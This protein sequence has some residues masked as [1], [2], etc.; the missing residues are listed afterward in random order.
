MAV[1]SVRASAKDSPETRIQMRKFE[2]VIDEPQDFGGNDLAPS[3]VEVFLA[4]LA[5][6]INAIGQWVA[7][8]RGMC[9]RGM[10]IK[11]DGVIDSD[12]FFGK[13]TN[14]RA[15]FESISALIRVDTDAGNEELR[16]WIEQIYKRCPV[17]DNICNPTAFQIECK[18]EIRDEA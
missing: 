8:E 7:H 18:K 11:L 14:K 17:I 13:P 1:I 16:E 15:G 9:L 12:R 6:C 10:Q 4:S 2:L 5:G 3:P